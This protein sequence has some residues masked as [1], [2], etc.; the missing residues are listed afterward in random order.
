MWFVNS[1]VNRSR[2]SITYIRSKIKKKRE[3]SFTTIPIG[4]FSSKSFILHTGEM[5]EQELVSN[6]R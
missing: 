2:G 4:F 5:G 3:Y 1:T 6:E